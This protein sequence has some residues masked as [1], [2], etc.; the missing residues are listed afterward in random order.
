MVL[1]PLN[2]L[3][4]GR[5]ILHHDSIH[6]LAQSHRDCHVVLALRYLTQFRESA[7]DP[8]DTLLEV[9]DGSEHSGIPFPLLL[10]GLCLPHLPL[11][12]SQLGL[13]LVPPRRVLLVTLAQLLL[14]FLLVLKLA[15]DILE[16][17]LLGCQV[18]A[19]FLILRLQLLE[20]LVQFSR[21]GLQGDQ[22]VLL[23]GH[24]P[25]QGILLLLQDRTLLS[26]LRFQGVVLV[27]I[28]RLDLSL[29]AH[30]ARALLKLRQLLLLELGLLLQ[31]FDLFAV[32]GVLLT[33]LL[34]LGLIAPQLL[35]DLV[36]LPLDVLQRDCTPVLAGLLLRLGEGL[37]N[38]RALPLKL[39]A[40][41]PGLVQLLLQA[42]GLLL[43]GLHGLA[44]LRLFVH[45]RL[46]LLG[47]KV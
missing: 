45:L 19:H 33:K 1:Q 8:V 41:A 38:L 6:V 21:L 23:G 14:L 4:G 9:G 18:S 24:A 25:L 47:L 28:P 29:L 43:K 22:C 5:D 40:L 10:V 17:L 12:L 11:K 13:K 2:T 32:L 36:D 15:R 34:D 39:A 7:V 31:A 35:D 20:P 44:E 37:R 3:L 26:G 42:T 27:L 46:D 30:A 16:C